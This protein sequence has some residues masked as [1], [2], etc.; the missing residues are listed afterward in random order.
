MGLILARSP[1]NVSRENFDPNVNMRVEIGLFKEGIFSVKQTYNINYRNSYF[2]DI[3]SLIRSELSDSYSYSGSLGRYTGGSSGN[4]IVRTTIEARTGG[5]T[6]PDIIDYYLAVDGYLY[7]TEPMNQDHTSYLEDNCYYAGSSDL[8]YKLDDS[9][10]RIA[11]INPSLDVTASQV[12]EDVVV[13]TFLNDS[14]VQQTTYSFD[15]EYSS[16]FTTVVQDSSYD[17]FLDRVSE[18]G[19]IYEEGICLLRFFRQN[20]LNNIDKIVIS[21]NGKSKVVRVKTIEES[22]YPPY[23]IT[24]KNRFGVNEDLWFFKKSIRSLSVKSEEF[25]ANQIT[26]RSAGNLSRS[27]QEYNKNG[28]ESLILN[29]GFVDEALN[30]SFKQLILSERVELYDYNNNKLSAVKI[31]D[32]ELKLKTSTNDK[33]INYTIEVEVS[34]N[35]IDDIV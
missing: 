13:T 32:S 9:N 24:F 14:E 16:T 30:E 15:S 22:K 27:I 33:L 26:S 31:K 10:V 8:I 23:R 21:S 34:N 25:R 7:S 1:F 4:V 18:D 28:T 5:S 12:T 20:K 35:I 3:S 19:G 17:S 29:S 2:V 11:L 6:V